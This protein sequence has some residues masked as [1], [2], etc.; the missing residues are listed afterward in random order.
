VLFFTRFL[1]EAEPWKMKGVD[2]P[3][4][5]KI[6]RTTL[7]ALY[8]LAHFLAPVI[9]L[10]AESIFDKLNTP[11]V[12]AFKLLSTFYN[13]KPGTLVSVG[14]ILF[15]KVELEDVT[16]ANPTSAVGNKNEKDKSSHKKG[17]EESTSKSS[18]KSGKPKPKV[19]A[20][21]NQGSKVEGKKTKDVKPSPNDD[22]G[23]GSEN[24]DDFSKIE[25]RVGKIVKVWPHETA[26]RY[27][28]Y[29]NN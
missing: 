1:T 24:Q 17:T 2:E 10:S 26:D 18:D 9:P 5:Q 3:R 23:A 21:H 8:I 22:N 11:P 4:K 20:E 13:L 19:D 7:E 14:E 27:V 12:P 29:I 25:L 16:A 28:K 6:V 15:Q